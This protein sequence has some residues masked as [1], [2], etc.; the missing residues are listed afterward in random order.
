MMGL[1]RQPCNILIV[2][3][4]SQADP[5]PEAEDADL[6]MQALGAAQSDAV[7]STKPP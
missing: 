5:Q 7:R 1:F 6:D 3:S 4:P 2:D